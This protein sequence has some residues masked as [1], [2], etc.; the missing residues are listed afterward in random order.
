MGSP[1]LEVRALEKR[2]RSWPARPRTVL[3]G[4]E[5]A[6]EAGESFG[7]IGPNGS[8]KSTLLSIL[9]GVQRASSGTVRVFGEPIATRAA[10]ARI[11]FAPDGFPFPPELT[12]RAALAILG[13]LHGA[14]RAAHRT[15]VERMLARVGLAAA[16]REPF[17]R[18]SLGMRRRFALGQAF[19]HGAELLLFDEPT[20]G[21]D[22]EGYG[23]LDE[24][25]RE[26]RARGATL[27]IASH[28]QEDLREHCP[29]AGV[30]VGGSLALQGE[31][32]AL[33]GDAAR[34]RALYRECASVERP[35]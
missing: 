31:S 27:L 18:F 33:L 8:G 34:L 1:A 30:L 10:R 3:A 15:A 28:V 9:A 7:L 25:L 11:G 13:A 35:R 12:P 14:P 24:L 5:L 22:A 19:L 20:A 26:A 21:L 4:I 6:L 32:S 17:A 23:V 29:R 16:A 2:Y